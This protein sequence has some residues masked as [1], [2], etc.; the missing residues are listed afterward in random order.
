MATVKEDET[1]PVVVVVGFIIVVVV[2][3][4]VVVLSRRMMMQWIFRVEPFGILVDRKSLRWSV[5][6]EPK[7]WKD[8][9]LFV[10]A[11]SATKNGFDEAI[12]RNPRLPIGQMVLQMFPEVVGKFW[13]FQLDQ[14]GRVVCV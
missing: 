5:T 10:D 7:G 9:P 2:V 4:F 12:L 1:C 11:G 13:R 8:S 6:H 3:V 14:F